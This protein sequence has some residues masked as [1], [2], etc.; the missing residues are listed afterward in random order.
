MNIGLSLLPPF[1]SFTSFLLSFPSFLSF[2]SSFPFAVPFSFCLASTYLPPTRST[3]Q[4]NS[5]PSNVPA[6]LRPG[7]GERGKGEKKRAGRGV[8]IGLTAPPHCS[9]A[10]QNITTKQIAIRKPICKKKKKKLDTYIH[11]LVRFFVRL[12]VCCFIYWPIGPLAHWPIRSIRPFRRFQNRYLQS[13][14]VK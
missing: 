2:L 7:G 14:R 1:L 13:R 5:N 11:S 4:E 10:H 8:Q 3:D 9:I 6:C 12:F